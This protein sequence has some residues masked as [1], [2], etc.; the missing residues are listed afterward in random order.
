[1]PIHDAVDQ[2]GASK[3]RAAED[4]RRR[5]P[6]AAFFGQE[7]P[8][9]MPEVDAFIGLDQITQVAP[10]IQEADGQPSEA[11]QENLVTRSRNTSPTTTPR[12]S[13]SRRSTWPTS[14]S[15]RA[16]TT[17]APSASSRAFVAATAAARR[18][19]SSKRRRQLVKSGVKEINL[20]SQDTTYFGMDKWTEERPKPRS[21]VDSTQGR[22]PLHPHPRAEQDRGRLLDPPALHAP[23]ALER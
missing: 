21:G 13:A 19:A 11:E 17:R 4:H 5:V 23:G 18:R 15:P 12:A 22:V 3:K 2:R 16:A 7:L 9:L 20:I 6:L 14:R 1:V 8:G 10:I